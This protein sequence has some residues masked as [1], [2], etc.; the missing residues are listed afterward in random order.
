[1][2]FFEIQKPLKRVGPDKYIIGQNPLSPQLSLDGSTLEVSNVQATQ[3]L[4]I[5][6]VDFIEYITGDVTFVQ[7]IVNNFT[8]SRYTLQE[9][10]EKDENG[11]LIPSNAPNISDTMWILRN[12]NDLELRANLWR[13]DTGPTAFTEDI[14]T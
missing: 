12:E 4:F 13:Y 5:S 11:D 8:E 3:G 10:F 9:A 7:N 6:G 2:Q 14:T 1:M